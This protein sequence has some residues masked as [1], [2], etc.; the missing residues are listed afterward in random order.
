MLRPEYSRPLQARQHEHDALCSKHR[1]FSHEWFGEHSQPASQR[2]SVYVQHAR[3]RLKVASQEAFPPYQ[4]VI[5]RRGAS[6]FICYS[7]IRLQAS[8][9]EPQEQIKDQTTYT[10]YPNSW[11][12][13]LACITSSYP[14]LQSSATRVCMPCIHPLSD[15]IS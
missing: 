8:G 2:L 7:S 13:P 1:G 4:E 6:P 15:I 5:T 3:D 11:I 12:F 9:F 14:K 10:T